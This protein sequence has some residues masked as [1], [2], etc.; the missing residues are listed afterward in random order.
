MGVR[1]PRCRNHNQTAGREDMKKLLA[2]IV[3]GMFAVAVTSSVIAQDQKKDQKKAQ[4]DKGTPAQGTVQKKDQQKAKADTAKKA[5]AKSTQKKP[6]AKST[7]KK[8]KAAP[9][10]KPEEMKK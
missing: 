6:P 5:P 10:K 9:A 4:V 7:E 3:A 1:L 2:A 8:A